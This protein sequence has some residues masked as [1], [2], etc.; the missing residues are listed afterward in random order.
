MLAVGGDWLT[1]CAT[2]F[3]DT[4]VNIA[5]HDFSRTDRRGGTG[6]RTN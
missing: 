6:I 3:G 5:E 4:E 2:E 1:L